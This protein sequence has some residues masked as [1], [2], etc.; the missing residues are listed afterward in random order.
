MMMIVVSHAHR[1]HRSDRTDGA[2]MPAAQWRSCDVFPARP[3]TAERDPGLDLIQSTTERAVTHRRARPTP[4]NR[5]HTKLRRRFLLKH[6]NP[7]SRGH[8]GS[9]WES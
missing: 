6:K 8:Y 5:H 1:F 7:G 2:A 9:N 3:S 4:K